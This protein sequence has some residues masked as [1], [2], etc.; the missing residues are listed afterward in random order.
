MSPTRW[1]AN[2]HFQLG[3]GH[4]VR[5]AE[6][7]HQAQATPSTGHTKHRPHQAQATPRTGHTKHRPHQAQGTE[8]V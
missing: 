2:M 7:A 5:P 3:F 8:V 6:E 1:A 4:N